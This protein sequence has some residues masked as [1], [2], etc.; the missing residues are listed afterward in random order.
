[1]SSHVGLQATHPASPST[2]PF[3]SLPPEIRLEIYRLALP[4]HKRIIMH[5]GLAHWPPNSDPA[6]TS[7]LDGR[8]KYGPPLMA[9]GLFRVNRAISEEAR[10]SFYGDNT[11]VFEIDGFPIRQWSYRYFRN[12]PVP[13]LRIYGP[14]G[15][16]ESLG[17]LQRLRYVELTVGHF[18]DMSW[19]NRRHRSRLQQLVALLHGSEGRTQLISLKVTFNAKSLPSSMLDESGIIIPSLFWMY[20]L[21]ELA[22]LR[23]ARMIEVEVKGS[24]GRNRWFSRCL[25]QAIAGT[26]GPLHEVKYPQV[27]RQKMYCHSE[28]KWIVVTSKTWMMP[29]YDWAEFAMRNGITL[30]GGS[31]PNAFLLYAGLQTQGQ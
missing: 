14:L 17:A 25:E 29:K 31:D 16:P 6:R 8:P 2:L 13:L 7:M 11:F 4:Y 24:L 30:P 12:L 26:G 27:R 5:D 3:L 10:A 20:P 9:A 18:K 23:C 28:K 21:E 1:M 22:R 15:K 19:T